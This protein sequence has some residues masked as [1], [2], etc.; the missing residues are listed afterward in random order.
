MVGSALVREAQANWLGCGDAIVVMARSV[1]D[2]IVVCK[3]WWFV[4]V[5]GQV[6]RSVNVG[7]E[8]EIMCCYDA[9][10][11]DNDCS[12]ETKIMDYGTSSY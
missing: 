10:M 2:E 5:A 1:T 4:V 9:I 12:I 7:E 6:V 3:F 8:I 11:I